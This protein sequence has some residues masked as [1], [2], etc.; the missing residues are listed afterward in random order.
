MIAGF[1]R[2]FLSGIRSAKVRRVEPVE[3]FAEE[4]FPVFFFIDFLF[5]LQL[6]IGRKS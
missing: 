3:G 1:L 6:S 2:Y 5:N 4:T